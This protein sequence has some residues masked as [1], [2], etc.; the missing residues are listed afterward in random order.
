VLLDRV[1]VAALDGVEEAVAQCPE[2]P[3]GHATSRSAGSV[4]C[5]SIRQAADHRSS[6]ILHRLATRPSTEAPRAVAVECVGSAARVGLS[7]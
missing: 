7:I 1:E 4:D 5:R 3:V 2:F 6:S